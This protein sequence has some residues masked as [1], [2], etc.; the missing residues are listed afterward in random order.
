MAVSCLRACLNPA[1]PEAA[2]WFDGAQ[3][4]LGVCCFSCYHGVC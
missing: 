2:V 1:V 3:A 4:T